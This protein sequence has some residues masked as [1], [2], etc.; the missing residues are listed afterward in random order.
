MAGA[1]R[2][3]GMNS[4]GIF[5]FLPKEFPHSLAEHSPAFR[6]VLRPLLCPICQP[7]LTLT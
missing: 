2:G 7:M 5:P 6:P 3:K 4:S 1:F